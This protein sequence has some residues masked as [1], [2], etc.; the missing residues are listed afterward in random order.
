MDQKFKNRYNYQERDQRYNYHTNPGNSYNRNS[1]QNK[2]PNLKDQFP[3]VPMIF[4]NKVLS[5]VIG[6]NNVL[7]ALNQEN[8][9][10]NQTASPD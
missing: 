1:R 10:I 6:E 4:I 2:L 7:S 9:K 8:I 5:E 3:S